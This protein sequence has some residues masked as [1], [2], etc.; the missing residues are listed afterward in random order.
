MTPDHRMLC[1]KIMVTASLLG[2]TL[3]HMEDNAIHSSMLRPVVEQRIHEKYAWWFWC[4][5][6]VC[7]VAA[8][9]TFLLYVWTAQ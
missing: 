2:F 3:F 8:V 7:T 1:I 9:I 4:G 5:A 6:A